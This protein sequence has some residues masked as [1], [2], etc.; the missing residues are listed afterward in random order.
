MRG[1]RILYSATVFGSTV[2][3][4]GSCVRI[5]LEFE[6]TQ[7]TGFMRHFPLLGL[8]VMLFTALTDS[9]AVSSALSYIV[10]V[11]QELAHV[12]GCLCVSSRDAS[13][14][15]TDLKKSELKRPFRLLKRFVWVFEKST[16]WYSACIIASNS[17]AWLECIAIAITDGGRIGLP[18]NY[19][20]LS[21]ALSLGLLMYVGIWIKTEVSK[22]PLQPSSLHGL[23][24]V[25]MMLCLI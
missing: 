25:I 15:R 24:Q 2:Y 11:G 12:Y 10:V 6:P 5:C 4:I 14:F 1:V 23:W 18:Y 9:T 7:I 20:S 17:M 22:S 19:Y 13:L 3:A 21:S 16:T 8:A